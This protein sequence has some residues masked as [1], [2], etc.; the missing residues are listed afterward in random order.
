[1]K[2]VARIIAIGLIGL[3]IFISACSRDKDYSENFSEPNNAPI[4]NYEGAKYENGVFIG[5]GWAA[6]KED[7]AP[8]KMVLVY[9]DGK[10][11]GEAKL[12]DDRPDVVSHFKNDRFLKSG[13]KISAKI[14]LDKGLHSS[15]ALIY[16]SKDAV[17]IAVKN[18][19]AE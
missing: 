14:P 16:D 11:V 18:F 5:G 17:L 8:L 19:T 2:S 13:W 4:G 7:G 1:M 6:D 12:I 15:M 3:V 9:V 10:P